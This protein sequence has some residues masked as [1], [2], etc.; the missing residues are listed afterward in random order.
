[1]GC[2]QEFLL[3]VGKGGSEEDLLVLLV[4]LCFLRDRGTWDVLGAP[5][6]T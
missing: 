5:G 4:S 6:V 2:A 3:T 1:M